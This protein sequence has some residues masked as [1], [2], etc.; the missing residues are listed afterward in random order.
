MAKKARNIYAETVRVVDTFPY[1]VLSKENLAMTL[2]Y[3]EELLKI[4][5]YYNT[6]ENGAKFTTEGSGGTYIPSNI[7]YKTVKNLID[8]QARFMFSRMPDINITS[9]DAT[10]SEEPDAQIEA[11][12]KI[13]NKVIE[14]NN[15]GEK[16]LKAAKDCFIGKR[17]ACLVDMSERS[18]IMIHFYMSTEFYYETDYR[19]GEVTKFISF[20]NVTQSKQTT[21]RRFLV[22]RY[23]IINNLVSVSSTLCDGSGNVI[24]TYVPE[25]GTDLEK[26]PVV[27]IVND[28]TLK[29][30]RGVSDIKDAASYEG[31]FSRV[32]NAE[33]DADRK[34]MNPIRFVVDMNSET[35]KNLPSGAGAFWDLEHNQNMEEPKPQVGQLAPAMNHTEPVKSALDRLRSMMYESMDIPDISKDGLLSGITSFKALKAL[36]YPLMVRCD[37]K[38]MVWKPALAELVRHIVKLAT[39]N[40]AVAKEL[41][42][43]ADVKQIEYDVE[44]VEN[45]ALIDDET[46]EKT[47]DME[48]I[49]VKAR[50]RRSYLKKWRGDELK[51]DDMIEQ[52][53]LW[54]A[55]EEST[56]DALS[57][58]PAVQRT[59]QEEEIDE[60][61]DENIERQEIED[62]DI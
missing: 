17:V 28:G 26:I 7:S 27:I 39:L 36:Y 41:Y 61:I 56:M 15:F 57:M 5:E 45:Y 33:I 23:E 51:T 14:K 16:L 10:G 8:K 6:Y 40:E 43:V 30:K 54:I 42:V 20:E 3:K 38:L 47:T 25:H 34:G 13:I 1:F 35:T 59:Q 48:E 32:A 21:N 9:S 58:G 12:K 18:G 44:I 19:T 2:E 52:E 4:Q 62:E 53:L 24:E 31:G 46:E 22:N 49:A 11:Y 60:Q 37:E 29:D 55:E 50:S